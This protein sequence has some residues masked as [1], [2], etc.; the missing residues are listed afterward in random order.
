[1]KE[2]T[3]VQSFLRARSLR[4]FFCLFV[5][6]FVSVFWNFFHCKSRFRRNQIAHTETDST[7]RRIKKEITSFFVLSFKNQM[8]C[9]Y[10]AAV[11]GVT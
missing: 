4:V 3:R 10:Q 7:Y 8:F 11:E 6:L 5:C 9:F 2:G 1:V